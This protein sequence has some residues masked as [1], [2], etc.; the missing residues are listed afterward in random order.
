MQVDELRAVAS[1]PD[2]QHLFVLQSFSAIQGLVGRISSLV[3]DGMSPQSPHSVSNSLTESITLTPGG[4]GETP[5]VGNNNFLFFKSSCP[6]RSEH[7]IVEVVDFAGTRYCLWRQCVS[8]TCG[9]RCL[10]VIH[11]PQPWTVRP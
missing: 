7:V 3:C 2:H 10:R 6:A 4:N 11:Q 1:D 5:S 8:L 9:Q